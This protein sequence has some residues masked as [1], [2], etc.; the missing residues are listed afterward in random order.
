MPHLSD[1]GYLRFR[2]GNIRALVS[3]DYPEVRALLDS[4][5]YLFAGDAVILKDGR[6]VKAAKV[7]APDSGIFFLKRYNNKG[8]LY[9]LRYI[10]RRPRPWRVK[11]ISDRLREAGIHTPKIIAA[12]V[13]RKW[14]V[15][16]DTS[17]L[18]TEFLD[19]LIPPEELV[20]QLLKDRPL[21]TEYCNQVVST[22]NHLHNNGFLHGDLKIANIYCRRVNKNELEVG[23]LDLDSAVYSSRRLAA[24]ERT[25]DLARFIASLLQTADKLDLKVEKKQLV[26][27]IVS[28]YE[29]LSAYELDKKSLVKMI[30]VHMDRHR[31]KY[32]NG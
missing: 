5:D 18:M 26:D 14:G 2:C 9:S 16:L 8:F 3:A 30:R 13:K 15:F 20:P 1:D 21:F 6:S 28:E 4:I 32:V 25:R 22:L 23:L 17:Y 31:R 7:E 19:D 27:F 24:K 11:I 12:V 10:F 29:K